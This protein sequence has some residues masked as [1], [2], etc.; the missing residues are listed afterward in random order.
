[1][2][3]RLR[4]VLVVAML[5]GGACGVAAQ[6]GSRV[7]VGGSITANI[8]P[9]SGTGGSATLGFE[10]RLGQEDPGWGVQTSIFGWFDT[11]IHESI[12]G[13]TSDWGNLR[14]RPIM[15]GYGYTW[16]RGR[17][18]LTA[19]VGGGYSLNS[20]HLESAA[21][22]QY[23]QRLS[24]IDIDSEATNAFAV[25]PEVQVWYDLNDRFGLKL[26]GGYLVER[27]SIVITSSIGRDERSIR[28]DAFVVTIGV[29]YSLF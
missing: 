15:A 24:A 25:K 29:V 11:G 17:A 27:P 1:M 14:L 12:A 7:A 26:T 2:I 3:T 13:I 21:V 22:N 20:F 4:G 5:F 10:L 28:A 8:L 6:T 18:S 16:V 19:D 23:A 9:A